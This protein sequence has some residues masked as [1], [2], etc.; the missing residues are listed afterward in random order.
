MT[1][2]DKAQKIAQGWPADKGAPGALRELYDRTAPD[3]KPIVG[4]F[5]EALM[6]AANGLADLALISESWDDVEEE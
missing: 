5:V 1:T 3:Q 4:M 6:A 2:F